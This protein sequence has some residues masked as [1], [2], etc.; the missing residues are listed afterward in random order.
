MCILLTYT[1]FPGWKWKL[2]EFLHSDYCALCTQQC[3]NFLKVISI[4]H[5][6]RVM[7]GSLGLVDFIVGLVENVFHLPSIFWTFF[8]DPIRITVSQIKRKVFWAS[9]VHIT[10]YAYFFTLFLTSKLWNRKKFRRRAKTSSQAFVWKRWA[11]MF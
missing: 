7:S 11:G 10:Y 5:A 1:A 2:N 8:G 6:K 3:S 4:Q 9:T